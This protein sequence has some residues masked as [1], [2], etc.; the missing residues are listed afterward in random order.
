MTNPYEAPQNLIGQTPFRVPL[1]RSVF[2]RLFDAILIW[3]GVLL[4]G[5]IGVATREGIRAAF[6]RGMADP[7][8]TLYFFMPVGGAVIATVAIWSW[9]RFR[10]KNQYKLPL[11]FRFLGGCIIGCATYVIATWLEPSGFLIPLSILVTA[12]V[13]YLEFEGMFCRAVFASLPELGFAN[14]SES[15]TS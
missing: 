7:L 14:N 9:V 5:H 13:L 1:P 8:H 10:G 12:S 11:G 15:A 4:G 6:D 3:F 2:R